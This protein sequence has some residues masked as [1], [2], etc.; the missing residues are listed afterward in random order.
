MPI[1]QD[2]Y[3]LRSIAS[4]VRSEAYNMDTRKQELYNTRTNIVWEGYAKQKYVRDANFIDSKLTTIKNRLLSYA[5]SLNSLADTYERIDREEDARRER[6]RQ[7]AIARAAEEQ[8]RAEEQ[9]KA[10]NSIVSKK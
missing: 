8:R 7:A 9:R 3:V 2:V 4:T 5:T 10:S 6:E 1:R